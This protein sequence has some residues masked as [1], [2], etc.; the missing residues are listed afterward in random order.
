M[1][2][3]RWG[4]RHPRSLLAD[5]LRRTYG[6]FEI[7]A[8][9]STIF[10]RRHCVLFTLIMP[11]RWYLSGV[12]SLRQ[13][14]VICVEWGCIPNFGAAC[15][16]TGASSNATAGGNGLTRIVRPGLVRVV[17]T[18]HGQKRENRGVRFDPSDNRVTPLLRCAGHYSKK[19]SRY[20]GGVIHARLTMCALWTEAAARKSTVGPQANL[21]SFG[22][23]LNHSSAS[24]GSRIGLY[25][26]SLLR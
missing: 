5:P 2:D 12:T 13:S 1:W 4:R 11:T 19:T 10:D 3:G 22:P 8:T 6:L 16:A 15:F 14:S 23:S 21:A 24:W 18:G 25:C 26:T 20:G 17:F 9:L 7:L